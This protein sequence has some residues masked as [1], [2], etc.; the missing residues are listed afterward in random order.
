MPKRRG[1]FATPEAYKAA[2]SILEE[3]MPV[4]HRL[5]LELHYH[6][7]KRTVTARS[8]AE[9]VGYAHYGA[10][11][12]QYGTLARKV[13]EI[14]GQQLKYHVLVLVEFVVPEIG[15]DRD[16]RWIMRPEVARALEELQWV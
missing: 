11:N 16:L 3:E 12:L 4:K 14:L 5:M 1:A 9:S 8:L 13:C 10:V 7:P 2:F 15:T 6:A